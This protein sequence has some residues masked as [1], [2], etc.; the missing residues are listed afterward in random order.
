MKLLFTSDWHI[1]SD[2]PPSR[3][4]DFR[5]KQF[6]ILLHIQNIAK[7][8]D[9]IIVNAGDI[10]HRACPINPQPLETMLHNIFKDI[11]IF[12]IPGQHDLIGHNVENIANGSIGVLNCF[13]NWDCSLVYESDN[14]VLWGTPYGEELMGD[15]CYEDQLLIAILHKFVSD[16]PL[17]PW[18]KDKGITAKELCENYPEF[19]VFVCGDNHKSFVYKHPKTNQLVFNCGCITRQKL[20][21]KN[22]QPC[23]YIYDTDTNTYETI[24]LFDNDPNV[25]KKTRRME[26]QEQR[27]SRIDSFVE[28]AGV[29]HDT[30]WEFE[31]NIK[32]YCIKNKTSKEVESMIKII[33]EECYHD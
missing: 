21:E 31:E 20:N 11:F 23:I 12:F 10:F 3:I 27:E 9:C 6:H 8:Y 22:Y 32:Q 30:T 1:R 15:G 4:D 14:F 26:I 17:P 16:S 24:E 28:L 29:E 7:K 2:K 18:L 25:L 19:N 5:V 33:L 13:N